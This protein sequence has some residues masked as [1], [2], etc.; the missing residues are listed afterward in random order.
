MEIANRDL[1]DAKKRVVGLALDLEQV[2]FML[3]PQENQGALDTY[4]IR[5]PRALA[6]WL[7]EWSA[8]IWV[9]E[10]SKNP[11][12]I[13]YVANR[14]LTELMVDAK[15][16]YSPENPRWSED[17]YTREEAPA[18]AEKLRVQFMGNEQGKIA[19][20]PSRAATANYTIRFDRELSA[21]LAHFGQELKKI[22]GTNNTTNN[23][24]NQQV[25]IILLEQLM[26]S[27]RGTAGAPSQT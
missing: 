11:P 4:T 26:L 16:Q 22:K 8:I 2:C 27:E 17:P 25:A 19:G 23:V 24:S 9:S 20:P 5:F 6:Q 18:K 15:R 1:S 13:Q 14:F 10:K 7:K 21:W 3:G 12:T